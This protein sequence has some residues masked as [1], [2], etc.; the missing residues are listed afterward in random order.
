MPDL[1][2]CR[3]IWERHRRSTI[4][5]EAAGV[6]EVAVVAGLGL[7]TEDVVTENRLF[8]Q[9]GFMLIMILH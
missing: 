6:A 3:S 7:L 5:F 4:A 9:I 2:E 8:I 1:G